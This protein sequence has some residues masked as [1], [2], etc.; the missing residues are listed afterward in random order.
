MFDQL[1]P[2]FAGCVPI[3]RA[4]DLSPSSTTSLTWHREWPLKPD[5]VLEGGNQVVKPGSTSVLDPDEMA[6]LTTAHDTAGRLLVEF[7]DTSAAVAQAARMGAILQAAY[8]KFWPETIRAL[9]IHSAEWTEPMRRAFGTRRA[10][11]VS[12]LRRYGYGLPSLGRALYSARSSL[13]LI[14]QQTIQPYVKEGSEV[15]TKDMGL[16][17]LPWPK[18][19]LLALGEKVVTMRVTLSYFIEP[20]PGRRDGFVKTRHR[21]QSHGLRFEVRRPEEALEQFR[22]RIT[23]AARDEE[24]EYEAVGD[25][26]GWELGPQ[27]RTRGSLHS[28]WWTGTAAAL[29]NS[30]H[31]AVYPVSGW[32][33]EAKGNHWTKEA[34]YSLV[35]TIRTEEAGVDI[36]TPVKAMIEIPI[37]AEIEMEAE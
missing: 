22:Q 25:T 37:E 31:I 23:K 21:Y 24:E 2:M 13:T 11:G 30:G 20:K 4:G 7:R 33:R 15:K 8:P 17:D 27:T 26:S 32:W 14:A 1:K 10:D 34:R 5:I 29:A 28:D 36:Y 12:R 6:L 3:A 35:V 16:H 18:E 19:Q 9:L